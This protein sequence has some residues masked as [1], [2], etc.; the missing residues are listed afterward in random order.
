[1]V[2]KASEAASAPKKAGDQSQFRTILR[3]HGIIAE[4]FGVT[5]RCAS[6]RSRSGA[7]R[8]SISTAPHSSSGSDAQPAGCVLSSLR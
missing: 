6:R 4:L 1:M 2:E 7:A 3:S 5:A 8:A